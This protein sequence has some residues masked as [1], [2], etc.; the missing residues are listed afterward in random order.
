VIE[1][2][3]APRRT[4]FKVSLPTVPKSDNAIEDR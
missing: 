3:S 4:V 2:D 1:F